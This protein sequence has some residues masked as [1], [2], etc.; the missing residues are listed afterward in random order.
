M[1]TLHDAAERRDAWLIDLLVDILHEGSSSATDFIAWLNFAALEGH[2]ELVRRLLRESVPTSSSDCD[3]SP[4][5]L[6][7]RR[8]HIEVVREIIFSPDDIYRDD[9]SQ[10]QVAFLVA[11]YEGQAKTA[12]YLLALGGRH[13]ENR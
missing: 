5:C 4:L 7:A 9:M 2:P 1:K 13:H 6:A 12:E 3:E 11:V 8:G 10:L